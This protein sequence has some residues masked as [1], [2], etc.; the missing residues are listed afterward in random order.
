MKSSA[1][2]GLVS[3]LP[4]RARSLVVDAFKKSSNLKLANMYTGLEME[5]MALEHRLKIGVV[6]NNENN[7]SVSQILKDLKV[8]EAARTRH[9]ENLGWTWLDFEIFMVD[10]QVM[11]EAV[12]P[13]ET[14]GS[15]VLT[16]RPYA[17]EASVE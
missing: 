11:T 15:K 12:P 2:V 1:R 7:R 5:Y 10:R 14:S 9:L 16:A 3:T 4:P 8:P 17:L 6:V 13:N